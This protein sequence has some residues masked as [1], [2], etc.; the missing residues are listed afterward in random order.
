MVWKLVLQ[1]LSPDVAVERGAHPRAAAQARADFDVTTEDIVFSSLVIALRRPGLQPGR[2]SLTDRGDRRRATARPAYSSLQGR[3][4]LGA[5]LLQ[6]PRWPARSPSFYGKQQ[7]K[8]RGELV[9]VLSDDVPC[10]PTAGSTIQESLLARDLG[11]PDRW[12]PGSWTA[13]VV[14]GAVVGVGAAALGLGRLWA[15]RSCKIR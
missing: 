15:D 7:V 10:W 1:E 14:A 12:R 5:S 13:T 8:P 3:P 11:L 2:R 6:R 9:M 4:A